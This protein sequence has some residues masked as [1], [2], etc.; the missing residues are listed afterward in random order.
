MQRCSG[1]ILLQ[2]GSS[3]NDKSL[4]LVDQFIVLG[5]N[6]SSTERDVNIRT[7]KVWVAFDVIRIIWKSAFSDKIKQKFFKGVIVSVLL[8]NQTT[9]TLTEHL[10]KKVRRKLYKDSVW[11]FKKIQELASDKTAVLRPFPSRLTNHPR[12]SR[13]CWRSMDYYTWTYQ[14]WLAI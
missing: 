9:W 3:L 2:M 1:R 5:S 8:Y 11:R 13:Y 7:G 12:H 10:E 6:I 14:C 4:I